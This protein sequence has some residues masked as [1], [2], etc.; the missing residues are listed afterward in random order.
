LTSGSASFLFT[1]SDYDSIEF[2]ARVIALEVILPRI[3][4]R[5]FC[6]GD[7][8]ELLLDSNSVNTRFRAHQIYSLHT[9][10]LNRLHRQLAVKAIARTFD[11]WPKDVR[12]G[13]E[14]GGTIPKRHGEDP[15]LEV[16]TEQHLID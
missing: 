13:L 16:D 14:N 6:E 9:F 15:E 1:I 5:C 8:C 4:Q 11:I 10:G 3:I 7:A 2:P 12:D